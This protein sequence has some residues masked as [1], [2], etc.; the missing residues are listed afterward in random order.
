MHP[1]EVAAGPF[2]LLVYERM[3]GVSAPVHIYIEGEGSPTP[4]DP[5][6]LKLAVQDPAPNVV[7]I[8]Q[9]C[10]YIS[11]RGCDARYW[12]YARYGDVALDAYR[13][14]LQRWQGYKLE[15]TG[16]SGGAALALLLAS[17]RD[18][19]VA[20]RTVAGD[21]DTDAFTALHH[22]SPLSE[23]LNPASVLERTAHIPQ[24]HFAGAD[25]GVVPPSLVA[26]YQ[27]RLPPGHCSAY[28]IV[29]GAGHEDGW[30]QAW[31]VL[32]AQPLPCTGGQGQ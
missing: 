28:N 31:P 25:D 12:T 7:Y 23:S 18:D 8:G 24:R 1:A 10:Q 3:A 2:T 32:L 30:T 20:I 14:A 9:A 27:N 22:I 21:V 13:Q 15:L 6:A 5:V 19:V 17:R 4:H 29:P 16:Y 26:N 11:T